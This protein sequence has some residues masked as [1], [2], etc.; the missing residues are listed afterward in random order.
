MK[1]RLVLQCTLEHA[2][3]I[4][5]K[6]VIYCRTTAWPIRIPDQGLSRRVKQ[7]KNHLIESLT[8]CILTSQPSCRG[9]SLSLGN[10]SFSSTSSLT[11]TL[12]N[13]SSTC[14][15]SSPLA[16]GGWLPVDPPRPLPRAR[17]PRQPLVPAPPLRREER[18]NVEPLAM[19]AR[20]LPSVV[21]QSDCA[22][23][24]HALQRDLNLDL[25]QERRVN[26][27][28]CPDKHFSPW[29]APADTCTPN[30]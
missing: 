30:W 11:F 28:H 7:S 29:A 12:S 6:V 10:P 3:V 14:V 1:V 13:R 5:N 17:T 24:C 25:I 4:L 18:P 19:I 21:V 9:P 15:P 23:Q 22:L 16:G 20:S 27:I 26:S 8:G 2:T